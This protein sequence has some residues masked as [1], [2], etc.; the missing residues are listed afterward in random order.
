MHVLPAVDIQGGRTVRLFQGVRDQSKIY[1]YSPLDAARRWADQGAAWLHV[2]DLDGAFD[3]RSGNEPCIEQI[4]G[5]LAIP[6]QVGGGVRSAE[7][8]R[9]LLGYGAARVV[10]GTRA[11]ESRA[12]LE[13]LAREFP[14]KIVVGV[15]A[16]DGFAAVRGWTETSRTPAAE[17]LRSLAGLDLAGVVYTDIARDGAMAGVNVEA[18]RRA[19]E[20]SP[21]PVVASGGV[22]SL[23]DVRALAGLPLFGMIVGKALYEGALSLREIL[24]FFAHDRQH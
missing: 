4:A 18:M 22:C 11:L 12:F 2:V 23:E 5:A 20:A 24:N 21:V 3:G 8:A 10:V 1:D 15:D 14:G 16:R 13:E 7:K 6:I 9:R 19:A 17:F